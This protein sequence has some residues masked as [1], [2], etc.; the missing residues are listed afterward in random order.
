MRIAGFPPDPL[1]SSTARSSAELNARAPCDFNLSR[2]RSLAGSSLMLDDIR[3]PNDV[4]SFLG[5]PADA[6]ITMTV[7]VP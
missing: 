3:T 2:G 6:D 7:L 5:E 1:P 4:T